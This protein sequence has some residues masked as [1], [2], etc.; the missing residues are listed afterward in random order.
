MV[1]RLLLAQTFSGRAGSSDVFTRT[2][3]AN[4]ANS[5]NSPRRQRGRWRRRGALGWP[6]RVSQGSA[7][8]YWSTCVRVR[9]AG[10]AH[11]ESACDKLPVTGALRDRLLINSN[12]AWLLPTHCQRVR[13]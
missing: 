13:E 2:L 7:M 1:G 12:G 10:R 4:S 3:C 11:T 8:L 9:P 5:A 6:E